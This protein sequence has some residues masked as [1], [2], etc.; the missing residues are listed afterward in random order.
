MIEVSWV[1]PIYNDGYL[2]GDF[3]REFEEV[4]SK[5]YGTQ[6]LEE[7]AEVIFVNDGSRNDSYAELKALGSKHRFV[8]VVDLSR[9]FGQH[10]AITAGYR[11]A[12]GKYV[13]CTNVDMEDPPDQLLLL[14]EK[15]RGG[16]Y[17][18]VG[19]RYESREMSFMNRLTSRLFLRFTNFLTGFNVPRDM[20]MCRLMER[21]LVDQY[22]Q[23]TEK[24][25]FL[26]GI[27]AWLG[28]RRVW[29]MVRHRPRR[30]GR[31]AYTFARRLAL[32]LESVI[33]FSDL[34]L[35]L[36]VLVG[37]L[38]AAAGFFGVATLVAL[39]LFNG[40][41]QAGYPSTIAAIVLM[42]GV[43]IMVTGIAGLYV[44]RVLRETQNRP[45]FV[46]RETVNL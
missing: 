24:S 43:Q 1:V 16:E 32:A 46:V 23:L 31:S 33:S 17:E 22:N 41:F 21:K 39:K 29:V 13:G 34:P 12:K 9:N 26:P 5:H 35:R 28:F 6:A 37:S 27:E 20:A 3:C 8:K 45:V 15:I 44:G 11:Y 19:G 42:A 25:R 14:L 10:V 30:K 7:K 4:F 40:D 36:A 18:F 2:A 38:V